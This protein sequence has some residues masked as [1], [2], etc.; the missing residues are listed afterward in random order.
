LHSLQRRDLEDLYPDLGKFDAL[1][2]RL[3]PKD[4]FLSPALARMF[5]P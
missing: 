4:R 2:A 1:R 5:R 3:D